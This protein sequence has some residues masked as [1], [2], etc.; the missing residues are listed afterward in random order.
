MNAGFSNLATLKANVLAVE[1]RPRTT[2]DTQLAAIGLGVASAI[3]NHCSRK[4]A[5]VAGDT[6]TF[7]A[8][9]SHFQLSR[10]PVEAISKIEL[11][12]SEADGWTT[13]VINDFVRTIDYERGFIYLPDVDAGEADQL[14]RFT[15]TAGYFWETKE[16][17]DAGYPTAQPVGSAPVPEDLKLAWLLQVRTTWQSVDKL[18]TDITKTGAAGE[19]VTGSLPGLDLIPGVKQMLRQFIRE[20]WV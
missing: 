15:Y 17:S 11:K 8:D 13:Q 2:W 6:E 10:K 4:F 3:E 12:L 7:A 16:T 9:Y 18:G 14:I 19:F 20:A 1:L 5:R